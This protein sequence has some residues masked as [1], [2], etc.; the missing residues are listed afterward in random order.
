NVILPHGL[1]MQ[2]GV[3]AHYF[4]HLQRRNL[5]AAGD[6]V[7]QLRSDRADFVLRV[8]QHGHDGRTLAAFGISL[9]HLGELLFQLGRERHR[10][11]SPST[12]SILPSAAIESAIS[13]FSSI[14][15]KPWRLPKLGV[16]MCTR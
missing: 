10:S 6:L 14:L 1:A 5:A 2:H 16:R 13:V 9:E 3:V 8:N 12:K 4:V 11:V 7:D 15:G